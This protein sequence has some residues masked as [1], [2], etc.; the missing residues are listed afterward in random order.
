MVEAQGVEGAGETR[1]DNPCAETLQVGGTDV[2][3][4]DTGHHEAAPTLGAANPVAEEL[5]HLATDW[6][7]RQDPR[8]LRRALLVILR[9]LEDA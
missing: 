4:D 8:A 2:S 6:E 3:P 7:D 5:R 1:H 9:D